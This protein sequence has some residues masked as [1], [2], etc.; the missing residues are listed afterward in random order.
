MVYGETPQW[1]NTNFWETPAPALLR[2]AAH[3]VRDYHST[4]HANSGL[5]P[6]IAETEG[7]VSIE[8][9]NGLPRLYFSHNASWVA[10]EGNW[11]YNFEYAR[12]RER[13]LDF[14]E[15]CLGR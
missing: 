11:Y 5:N 13:G 4:T 7:S 12:E 3:R 2:F 14:L 6:D 10:G 9:Y 15:I 1:L 8:P